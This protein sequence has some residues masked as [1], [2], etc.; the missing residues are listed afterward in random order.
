MKKFILKNICIIFM[1]IC[2]ILVFPDL[3]AAHYA[4][5]DHTHETG[6]VKGMR[7]EIKI[8]IYYFMIGL[9]L[10]NYILFDASRIQNKNNGKSVGGYGPVFWFAVVQ[11][12]WIAGI[13]LYLID[14]FNPPEEIRMRIY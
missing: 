2:L 5:P 3:S 10:A 9:I 14:R 12:C 1:F 4:G 13:G 7:M 11:I 8:I 6:E